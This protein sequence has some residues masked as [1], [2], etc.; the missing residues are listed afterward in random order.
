MPTIIKGFLAKI[1]IIIVFKASKT[2]TSMQNL[3]KWNI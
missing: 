1:F 2:K 3:W